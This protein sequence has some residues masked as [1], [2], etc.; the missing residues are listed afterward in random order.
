MF[1]PTTGHILNT[2]PPVPRYNSHMPDPLQ[3]FSGHHHRRSKFVKHEVLPQVSTP[4]VLTTIVPDQAIPVLSSSR[5]ENE[6]A[7]NEDKVEEVEKAM[8]VE[9]NNNNI[10]QNT[11]GPRM[12]CNMC[13]DTALFSEEEL[14]PHL[15]AHY[16]VMFKCGVC[17][18]GFEKLS[19]AVEH[20]ERRHKSQENA[21]VIWPPVSRLLSAR[22]KLRGCKR[23]L[24]GVTEAEIEKHWETVHSQGGKNHKKKWQ[25][26]FEWRCRVCHNSGRRLVGQ[27]AALAHV[28]EHFP[29]ED[30]YSSDT[31]SGGF[32]SASSY[33]ECDSEDSASDEGSGGQLVEQRQADDARAGGQDTGVGNLAAC[34]E[35]HDAR[36]VVE[37]QDA[38]SGDIVN[39]GL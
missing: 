15:K 35:G 5:G 28:R 31:T 6:A 19:E 13:V 4:P 36:D 27:S 32:S 39:A 10:M 20:Q 22:C 16:D 21:E 2:P 30:C 12:P 1:G 29:G 37:G 11:K 23:V 9:C 17:R 25:Q 14:R 34:P 24:V 33:E 38:L 18:R 26:F 7:V 3:R 8:E